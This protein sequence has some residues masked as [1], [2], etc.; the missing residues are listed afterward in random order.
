M[1]EIGNICEKGGGSCGFRLVVGGGV[2]EWL[3]F[4]GGYRFPD[5]T[6][7]LVAVRAWSS[8]TPLFA[9]RGEEH[10]PLLQHPLPPAGPLA[11]S[12]G[13]LF[14]FPVI[15]KV[16]AAEGRQEESDQ[17]KYPLGNS[18]KCPKLN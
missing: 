10:V 17:N 5:P 9:R 11:D 16:Q 18:K 1:R 3:L 12:E 4:L 15:E 8:D 6:S 14:S 7:G 13:N 2:C